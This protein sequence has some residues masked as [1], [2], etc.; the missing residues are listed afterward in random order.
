MDT[1]YLID[2]PT[3]ITSFDVIRKLRKIT[4]CKK[5]WH[6]WTLDPLASWL[7]LIWTWNYTKL[8]PYFEKDTKEYEFCVN[9]DWVSDSFDAE[10]EVHYISEIDKLKYKNELNTSK[11]KEIL[12]THF[13][14]EI[15]QLPPKYSALKIWWEKA[16]DLVRNWVDF[17]LQSRKITV[18]NIDIISFS[19]PYLELKAKVS[20]WTY[21]RS[22][23]HDLWKILWTGWYISK[24]RRT[25][26]W[27]LDTSLSV[28]LDDFTTNYKFEAVNLFDKDRFITLNETILNKVNNWLK[29][30]LKLDLKENIDYFIKD[31]DNNITNIIRY[32]DWL[33]I[34]VKKI[35]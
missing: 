23:A 18:F 31:K 29:Q 9:L 19:Y 25:K 22:I 5:M 13:I 28:P 21:I 6:T 15:D 24:L 20:A 32:K 30:M 1:F 17:E 16:L 4:W 3:W 10:T 7:L 2:K 35:L 34:P 26:I 14:W 12:N 8:I 11:I 33:L 27:K